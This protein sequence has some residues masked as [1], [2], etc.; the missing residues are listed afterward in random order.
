MLQAHSRELRKAQA[1]L[2]DAHD[3]ARL[4]TGSKGEPR[5][6][7]AMQTK[8]TTAQQ[9]IREQQ[10]ALNAAHDEIANAKIEL[11]RLKATAAAQARSRSPSLAS[12]P[13]SPKSG[14]ASSP[15]PK[16]QLPIREES[17]RR[18][19]DKLG[20]GKEDS[21]ISNMLQRAEKGWGW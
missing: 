7:K 20:G 21:K 17:P 16:R 18:R 8:L 2:D 6:L 15:A 12:R 1:S 11:A 19:M 4:H 5:E 3:K 9:Q 14:R 10:Q 13:S